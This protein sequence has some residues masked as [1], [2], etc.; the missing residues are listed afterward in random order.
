M[1]LE[2][3]PEEEFAPSAEAESA[4]W[5]SEAARP[6]ARQEIFLKVGDHLFPHQATKIEAL[7]R[8]CWRYQAAQFH[9]AIG[10]IGHLESAHAPVP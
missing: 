5:A 6:A 7:R 3:S 4:S 1:N 10:Q 8:T 9:C 2:R